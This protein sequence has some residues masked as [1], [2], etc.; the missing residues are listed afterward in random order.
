M[1]VHDLDIFGIGAC[2][3]KADAELVVHAD[4]PLARAITLQVFKP[5]RRWCAQIVDA[6]CQVELLELAQR[7][8]LDISESGNAPEPEQ[9]FG[10]GTLECPDRHRGNSNVFRD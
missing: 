1:V 4:A 7:R 3:A 9:G 6:S 5:V 10:I 8:A 2:P